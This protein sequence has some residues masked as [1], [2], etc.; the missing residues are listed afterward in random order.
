MDVLEKF[1]KLDVD[2]SLVGLEKGA[3]E[4][5]YFCTPI[6]AKVIGWECEGIHYCFI[7]GFGETVFAVNPE[8]AEENYVRPLA[9]NFEK[10]VSL[11]LATKG[12]T[13]T[14][15][16][17]GWTK[18]QFL[19]FVENDGAEYPDF[20][21]KRKAVLEKIQSELKIEPMEEPF[22]YVKKIQ[23]E[24]DYSKIRFTEEYYDVL[25]LEVPEEI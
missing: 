11:F 4:G 17:S 16:I 1:E 2:K 9:E 8:T 14:E 5:G 19:N 18:E 12:T 13:A 10:F 7:E 15:Q 20:I 23:A 6:G 21:E 22:E 3:S 25:G 24:F